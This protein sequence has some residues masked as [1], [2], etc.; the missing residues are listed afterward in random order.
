MHSKE[1]KYV[2]SEITIVKRD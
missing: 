2:H 1:E